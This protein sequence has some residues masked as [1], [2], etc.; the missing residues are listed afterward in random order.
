MLKSIDFKAPNSLEGNLQVFKP[1]FIHRFGVCLDQICCVA[2]HANIV[3][4]EHD[5][6]VLG[7]FSIADLLNKWNQGLM[8]DTTRFYGKGGDVAQLQAY[9]F[10]PRT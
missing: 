7:T 9:E 4:T 3:Q 1:I 10:V 8:I 5:N 2:V 6:P